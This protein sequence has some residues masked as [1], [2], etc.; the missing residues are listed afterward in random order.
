MR[1]DE[2]S[3]VARYFHGMAPD[4]FLRLGIDRSKLPDAEAWSQLLR[5]DF[6]RP[7][8][9][10]RWHYVAWE[11]EGVAVGHS[12]IGDIE[13]GSH[14]YMHLHL[15]RA[16]LRTQGLGTAFVRGSRAALLRGARHRDRLLS[17]ECV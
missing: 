6:E 11:L 8:G 9:A 16:D 17:A 7:V 1:A 13:R 5:E 12:N 2:A 4:D 10:R 14:G 15:W 3:H